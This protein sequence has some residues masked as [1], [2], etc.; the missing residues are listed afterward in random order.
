M[1]GAFIVAADRVRQGLLYRGSLY[2]EKRRESK[3]LAVMGR[4]LFTEV[5]IKA[6]LTVILSRGRKR[7]VKM[8]QIS[9]IQLSFLVSQHRHCMWTKPV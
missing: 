7:S 5:T 1:K 9:Y 2:S 8:K 6:G 3:K 4:W